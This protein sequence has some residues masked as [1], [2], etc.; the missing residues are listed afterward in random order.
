MKFKPR[1]ALPLYEQIAD[2]I[3][4]DIASGKIKPDEQLKSQQLL[5][6]EYGVSLI[7]IK[8]ALS[9]LANEDLLYSKGRKGTYV[10]K[11]GSKKRSLGS[12]SIGMVLRDM[13]SPFFSLIMQNIEAF[14]SQ[15][16]YSLLISNSTR[17]PDK[18]EALI[19][20]F[21]DMG[22]S[23]LIIASMTHEYT[24]SHFL[25]M[26]HEQNYPLVMVSYIKDRDIP[27]VGTDHEQGGYLATKHLINLGYKKIGFING[28]LNNAVGDLRKDGFVRALQ[29]HNLP[30][31]ED[32]VY[33]LRQRGE[34]NDY[35]SGYDIGERFVG[36]SQRPDAMFI[37]N[38]LSALGFEQAVLDGGLIIPDDVALV[39]FDGIERGQFAPVPLTTIQ[40]PFDQIGAMAVENLIKRI[41]G[42]PVNTKTV[43]LPTLIVRKSCGTMLK[44]QL[45]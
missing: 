24:A 37:Y 6:K 15:E 3:R 31:R 9:D 45:A 35:S 44:H 26:I 2:H 29:E 8:R 33:R 12:N 1:N 10:Q 4:S 23:G 42:Q 43:L 20:Q 14:A 13:K 41:E 38:D 27:F 25:R 7:T 21:Y 36:L 18:E 39:G 22:V 32:F 17:Q 16:G 19:R 40:Q 11:L 28:E 30:V 34:W 5:A